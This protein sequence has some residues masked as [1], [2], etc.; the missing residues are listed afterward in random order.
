MIRSTSFLPKKLPGPTPTRPGM[1]AAVA[2][3]LQRTDKDSLYGA[4]LAVAGL[5]SFRRP[6]NLL[7]LLVSGCAVSSSRVDR[8]LKAV[9]SVALS[10]FMG[11][12]WLG[13]A[14]ARRTFDG[15]VAALG[16]AMG[17]VH[18]AKLAT[19]G[20]GGD[21]LGSSVIPADEN[22][23]AGRVEKLGGMDVYVVGRPV[24]GKAIVLIYD[25]FGVSAQCRHNCDQLAEKGFLVVMPDLFRGS[26]RRDPNFKRPEA[27]TVDRE[28]LDLVVPFVQAKGGVQLGCIGFCFGGGACMR[29]A[30]SGAF[31]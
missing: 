4:V 19:G 6:L 13:P 29:L 7:A 2:A 23:G 25:I 3:A 1:A 26:G 28:I 12:R 30:S 22:H 16:L 18:A 17:L 15:L 10:F 24:G 5:A 8:Q 11:R 21:G 14:S 9:W 20:D 27:A 31:L